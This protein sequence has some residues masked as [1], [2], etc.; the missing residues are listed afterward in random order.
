MR[1]RLPSIGRGYRRR[2]NGAASVTAHARGQ[3]GL[4]DLRQRHRRLGHDPLRLQPR[5]VLLP[6]LRH[7]RPSVRRQPPRGLRLA[8]RRRLLPWRRSGLLRQLHRGDGQRRHDPRVRV[9]RDHAGGAEPVRQQDRQ[10]ARLRLWARRP[11]P[12]CAG[13]RLPERLRL[14]PGMGRGLG[15]R[16]RDRAARRGPAPRA[17]GE[18]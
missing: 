12:L 16:T 7:V 2:R 15:P 4:P 11:R 17:R 6:A 5:R 10:V 8:L 9:A 1:A 13:S 14:R 3:A 18:L